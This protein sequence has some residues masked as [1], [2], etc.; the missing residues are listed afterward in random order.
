MREPNILLSEETFRCCLLNYVSEFILDG[1][2]FNF[3]KHCFALQV[4]DCSDFSIF[5]SACKLLPVSII[6]LNDCSISSY[7]SSF[8]VLNQFV[9]YGKFFY[10]AIL[11]SYYIQC[12]P[13]TDEKRHLSSYSYSYNTYSVYSQALHLNM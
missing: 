2:S 10:E 7:A 9:Y 12:K 8:F 13:A 11:P 5:I 3:A 6:Y 4:F 1:L